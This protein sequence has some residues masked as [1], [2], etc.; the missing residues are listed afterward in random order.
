[1]RLYRE[2]DRPPDT[3]CAIALGCFDGLH[4]GH[5]AVINR[6]AEG[7]EAGL[8]PAV[9]TFESHSMKTLG[10]A[11]APEVMTFSDKT[12]MLEQWGVEALFLERFDTVQGLS[13]ETFVE[14]ILHKKYQARLLCCGFNYRFGARSAGNAD[15]LVRLGARL[16]IEVAVCGAVTDGGRPI[17]S[18]RIREAVLAGDMEA[19]ARLLGRPFRYDF[20]VIRGKQVGRLLGTPTLNQLFEGD[21]ILPK[22]GVYA[23]SVTLS[24]KRRYAVTNVGVRPTVGSEVPLSETWIPGFSGDLYGHPVQ[25]SLHCFLRPEQKFPSLEELREAILTDGVRAREIVESLCKNQ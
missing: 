20:P 1:M 19:A 25:V 16:G 5:R 6:A 10:G 23:S 24:G 18:T 13:P 9:F 12:A 7:K 21:F 14:E 3:P 17:S 22:F 15:D 11:A 2:G 8:T 4:R